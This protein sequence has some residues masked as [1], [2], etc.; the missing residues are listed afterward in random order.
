MCKVC[1]DTNRVRMLDIWE[2]QK[3][4]ELHGGSALQSPPRITVP[5][6][7]CRG[8]QLQQ[9]IDQRWITHGYPVAGWTP[10]SRFHFTP[11]FDR[12]DGALIFV[13]TEER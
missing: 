4:Q 3:W 1:D 12:V 7:A 11:M 6:P 8:A 9:L 5:C 10:L 13:I 2:F